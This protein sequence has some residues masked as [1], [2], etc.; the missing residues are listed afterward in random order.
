M[1]ETRAASYLESMSL[2]LIVS[3]VIGLFLLGYLAY[4]I[5]RPDKF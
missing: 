4:S 2:E 3:G 1:Y 5:V